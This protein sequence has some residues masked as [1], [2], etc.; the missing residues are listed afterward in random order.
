[1]PSVRLSQRD[2]SFPRWQ[3]AVR[4][5]VSETVERKHTRRD[6]SPREFALKR[7]LDFNRGKNSIA[8]NH[9]CRNQLVA[10]TWVCKFG[11][12]QAKITVYNDY[13]PARDQ[14]ARDK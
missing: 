14:A 9:G 1:M 10:L 3:F 12:A 8:I 5:A 6:R 13:L 2:H 4:A 7:R 11:Y